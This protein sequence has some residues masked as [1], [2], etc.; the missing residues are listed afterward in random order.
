MALVKLGQFSINQSVFRSWKSTLVVSMQSELNGFGV[1]FKY[2]QP[3][4]GN[5]R[6]NTFAFY[7]PF[8]GGNFE[9]LINVIILRTAAYS[10]QALMKLFATAKI[11]QNVTTV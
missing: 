4:T 6:I 5:P 9:A 2:T 11:L 10:G 7:F 8:H 1:T 3:C